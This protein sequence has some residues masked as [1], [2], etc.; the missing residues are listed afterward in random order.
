MAQ[1]ALLADALA[2]WAALYT[3]ALFICFWQIAAGSAPPAAGVVAA[4][5]IAGAT[6]LLDRAKLSDRHLDPADP[7]A[8]PE[9]AAVIRRHRRA[10]RIAIPILAAVGALAAVALHPL[11]A[12]AAPASLIGVTLYAGRPPRPGHPRLKDRFL[13]KNLAIGA[14]LTALAAVLAFAADQSLPFPPAALA[15]AFATMMVTADAICCDLDDVPADARFATRTLPVVLGRRRAAAVA[16]TIHAMA[17]AALL[18]AVALLPNPRAAAIW[19]IGAPLSAA[20]IC[21]LRRGRPVRIAIDAR[22]PALA[23]IALLAA[24]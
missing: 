13:L 4:A 19:A 10:V 3:C 14:G 23:I 22:L 7:A 1:I 9:R 17:G 21:I 8:H 5:T 6:Y 2:L 16:L 24:A 11:A 15:A 20:A 18:P 12:I